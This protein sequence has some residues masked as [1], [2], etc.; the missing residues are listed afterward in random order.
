MGAYFPALVYSRV[1]PKESRDPRYTSGGN[2]S[3]PVC[4]ETTAEAH[5]LCTVV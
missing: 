2:E 4:T 5:K 3:A 1:S